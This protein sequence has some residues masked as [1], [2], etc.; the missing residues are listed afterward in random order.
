MF[1]GNDILREMAEQRVMLCEL[2]DAVKSLHRSVKHLQSGSRDQNCLMKLPDKVQ[3]PLQ[4]LEDVENLEKRLTDK[5]VK[6]SLVGVRFCHYLYLK[7]V[8]TLGHIT[9]ACTV[10]QLTFDIC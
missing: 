8:L 4:S 5:Q 7:N 10:L 1:L 2:V 9:L 6:Q 3:L